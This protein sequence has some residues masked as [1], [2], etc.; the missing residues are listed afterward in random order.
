MKKAFL[1]CATCGTYFQSLT[2]RWPEIAL[3]GLFMLAF[4]GMVG[5]FVWWQGKKFNG[6]SFSFRDLWGSFFS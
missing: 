5:S 2:Y 4:V 3:G 6:G 1:P